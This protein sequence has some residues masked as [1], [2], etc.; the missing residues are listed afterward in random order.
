MLSAWER[1]AGEAPPRAPAR[2][3]IPRHLQAGRRSLPGSPFPARAWERAEAGLPAAAEPAPR[4]PRRPAVG[5]PGG[6]PA[7]AVVAAAGPAALGHALVAQR[8]GGGPRA[9]RPHRR[10]RGRT[11]RRRPRDPADAARRGI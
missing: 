4:P 1:T 11:V 5:A 7:R 2:S 6:R 8:A 9:R 10:G 3:P